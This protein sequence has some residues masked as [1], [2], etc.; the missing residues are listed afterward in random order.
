MDPNSRRTVRIVLLPP[1]GD[2]ARTLRH[3]DPSLLTLLDLF[4]L[5]DLFHGPAGEE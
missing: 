2:L 3:A 1:G 4:G 5:G